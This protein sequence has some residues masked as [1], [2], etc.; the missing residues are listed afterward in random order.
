MCGKTCAKQLI[1]ILNGS[2]HAHCSAPC[3]R[4]I[5]VAEEL[6]LQELRKARELTQE[7]MAELLQIRQENVSRLEKRS[8]LL[9][10]TL[11]SY[12]EAMGGNLKVIVEFP[13]Q[14]PIEID[15]LF[16][17]DKVAKAG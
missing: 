13:E 8:D 1:H 3:H 10:S 11:R 15:G 17:T 12:I 7:R 5:A 16:T 9:V 6:S 14:P 2:H 4:G